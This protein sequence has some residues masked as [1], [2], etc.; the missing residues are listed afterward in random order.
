M[1]LFMLPDMNKL[2]IT[3]LAY[4]R[5]MPPA[6]MLA[7]RSPICQVWA[8]AVHMVHNVSLNVSL[9]T[10]H[11]SA[12]NGTASCMPD[13]ASMQYI[14]TCW[15]Q[16]RCPSPSRQLPTRHTITRTIIWM[17]VMVHTTMTTLSYSMYNETRVSYHHVLSS[18]QD[19]LQ[20][21]HRHMFVQIIIYL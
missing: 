12:M 2:I 17:Y 10:A 15:V 13:A 1:H 5:I 19:Y 6:C 21:C 4:Y 8:S 14:C 18:Q 9:C 11:G 3:I 16:R 20:T 7:H